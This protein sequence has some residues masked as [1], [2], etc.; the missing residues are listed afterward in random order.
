MKAQSGVH[1]LLTRD[2]GITQGLHSLRQYCPE[3]EGLWPLFLLGSVYHDT[4]I[5]K[6]VYFRN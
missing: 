6:Y 3:Q 2:L 4:Q 1:W 5:Y